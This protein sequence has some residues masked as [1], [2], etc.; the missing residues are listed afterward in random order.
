MEKICDDI[1]YGTYDDYED[2][3]KHNKDVA[4][5]LTPQEINQIKEHFNEVKP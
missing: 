4:E 1:T 3:A 2:F 5:V